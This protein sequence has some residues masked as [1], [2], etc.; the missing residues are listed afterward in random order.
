LIEKGE[1]GDILGASVTMYG[2]APAERGPERAWSAKRGAGAN[3][4][5]I[6]G[7]HHI[8]ALCA[9]IGEFTQGSAPVPT[10]APP[11]R[12]TRGT[13]VDVDA[14]DS[15]SFIATTA[16]GAEVSG[17]VFALPSGRG[18]VRLTVFGS[19]GSLALATPQG[20]NIG[21]NSVFFGKGGG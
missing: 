16:G 12:R 3:T 10:K 11:W 18:E 4:L 7:G 6:M 17:H 19:E 15:V 5:T 14:P 1:I 8:D 20:T 9:L 2:G 21:P 13:T